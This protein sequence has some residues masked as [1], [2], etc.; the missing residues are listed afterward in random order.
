MDNMLF[1]DPNN[2]QYFFSNEESIKKEMENLSRIM[3]KKFEEKKQ[4]GIGFI[5]LKDLWKEVEEELGIDYQPKWKW[6]D[7]DGNDL[8]F[9]FEETDKINLSDYNIREQ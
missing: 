9:A 1:Y 2:G 7:V 4:Q 6:T 5:S 3:N 8:I